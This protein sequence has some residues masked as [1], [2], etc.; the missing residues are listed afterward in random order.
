LSTLPGFRGGSGTRPR[1]D[2]PPPRPGDAPTIGTRLRVDVTDLY[3]AWWDKRAPERTSAERGAATAAAPSPATGAP[4]PAWTTTSST[5]SATGPKSTW[6]PATGTG[7]APD[8]DPTN[9][10]RKNKRP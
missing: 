9:R 3:D 10:P 4:A 7:T 6:K 8:I 2:H 5:P 1:D